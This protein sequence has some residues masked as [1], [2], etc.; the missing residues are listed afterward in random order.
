MNELST[1]EGLPGWEALPA[2]ERL[3]VRKLHAACREIAAAPNKMAAYKL[4]AQAMKDAGHPMS[5][6]SVQRKFLAW[7]TSGSLLALA[8][9][10]MAGMRPTR[11]RVKHPGFIAYWTELQT[12]CQRNGGQAYPMLLDIWRKKIE[13]IPGY[14]GWPGHPQ[15]PVGWSKKNLMR[16]KPA[17]L[18]ARVMR[19]GVKAAAPLLPMVLTTR[20]GM[21]A[22]EYYVSDDN[23]VDAHVICGK[24]IVRPLQLGCLDIATGKWC[25]GA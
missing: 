8:D 23:W 11:A 25:T 13:V 7:Q 24:Q 18:E 12:R 22:G 1:I 19:E 17:T 16:I 20:V 15:I 21:E 3:K 5:W 10:R 6:Q 2:E 14:E 9:L 4:A